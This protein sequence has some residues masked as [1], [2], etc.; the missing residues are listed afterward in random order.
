MKRLN[1]VNGNEIDFGNGMKH[2][3]ILKNKRTVRIPFP[4]EI[5]APMKNESYFFR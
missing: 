1:N 4:D 5:F 2:N 3:V